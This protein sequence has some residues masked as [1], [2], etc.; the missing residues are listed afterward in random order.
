MKK[1]ST[2]V[3]VKHFVFV[4]SYGNFRRRPKMRKNTHLLPA[5]ILVV[6]V[7]GCHGMQQQETTQATAAS[8]VTNEAPL[9]K[10]TLW[11]GETLTGPVEWKGSRVEVAGKAVGISEIKSIEAA[12]P[13]AGA[14]SLGAQSLPKGYRPLDDAAFRLYRKRAETAAAQYRGTDAVF[15][16]DKGEDLLRKDSSSVYRYHALFYILK[17]AARKHANISLSFTEGRSRARVLFARTISPDGKSRWALPGAFK[18]SVPPQAP[19]FF[20]K[21]SRVLSGQVPGADVGM[22]VEYAYEYEDYKPEIKDFFFPG[23]YFQQDFPVLDSVI[24]IYI[25][26]GKRLNYVTRNMPEET[27]EPLRLERHGYEGYRWQMHNVPP[28]EPEPFMPA[29]TDVNPS[30][31]TSLYFDWAKF[32]APTG[33]FQRERVKVTPEIAKRAKNITAGKATD[34]QKVAAIYYWIERNIH[35]LSIKASLSSGWA[36]HPASETLANGYG[37]CTDVA[38]LMSSLCRAVGIDAYPAI[39]R[40]NDSGTAVTEIP[41]PDANHAIALVF[42]GGKGRFIDPTTSNYRYPYL[43]ADDHGVKAVIYMK[44]EILDVPVPPPEDNMRESTQEMVILPDGSADIV[45]NNA[46]NGPYEA[47]VRGYWR[48]VPPE[49]HA[50]VM[51]Q[52]L[53]QR[54]PGA[55]LTGFDL[56]DIEDL[57][58]QLRMQIKYRIPLVGTRVKDLF[59]FTL[60][61]FQRHFPEAVLSKRK[62]DIEMETTRCYSTTVHLTLPKGFDLAGVPDGLAINGKHLF[63]RA[64]VEKSADGRSIVIKQ[65]FKRLTRKVPAADYAAYRE[66]AARIAAWTDPRIVLR[67]SPGTADNEEALR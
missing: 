28:L 21:R 36:G 43:R 49:Y 26:S 65:L 10:T 55:K 58:K 42:P 20:D 39:I 6:L 22:F 25:P 35:Y 61:G 19:Q 23:Y 29:R 60:S 50:R 52:Y 17:D 15:C 57:G 7:A 48:S 1:R 14:A 5:L 37:D 13:A 44:G 38:N 63:F 66:N 30:L 12:V 32:M 45:E 27:R 46:Y 24:D 4:V 16:L 34:D 40:T 64:S 31:H 18:V 53:Q 2:S 8:T 3:R 11:N 62:F 9:F 56:G 47:S 41:N 54:V 51:Q 33:A 67:E 59:I